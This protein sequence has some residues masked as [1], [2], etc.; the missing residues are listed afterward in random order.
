MDQKSIY[1][2]AVLSTILILLASCLGFSQE[3]INS[4]EAFRISAE[5]KKPVLL[6]FSGSDWCAPCIRF[7]KKI[8]SEN[9]F[10]AYAKDHLVILKA[11][12][13][14][15]KKLSE[16]LR[17]QNDALAEQYNP[18]GLFPHLVL[19]TPDQSSA[20]TLMYSNQTSDEFISE[21]NAHTFQ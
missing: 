20:T 18:N 17:R 11:D 6:V 16:E 10:Q 5:T 15:R 2:K 14:Q 9:A 8:L 21:I 7:E 19:L 12:F 3:L 4:K 13:P 1:L